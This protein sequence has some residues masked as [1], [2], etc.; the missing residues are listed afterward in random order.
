MDEIRE[1]IGCDGIGYLSMEGMYDCFNKDQGYCVGC[2]NGVY[3]VSTP[4]ESKK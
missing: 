4:I 2:F 3:P 1:L